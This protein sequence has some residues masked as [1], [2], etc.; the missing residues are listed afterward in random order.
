[1][2]GKLTINAN[3]RCIKKD[4]SFYTLIESEEL[5]TVIENLYFELDNE[6]RCQIMERIVQMIVQDEIDTE[7]MP[8]LVSCLSNT[9]SQQIKLDIFPA[10]NPNDEALIDSISTPLFVMFRNQFQLCKEEDNRRTLLARVL[11]ELQTIQPKIGYLLLY[12]LKIWGKEEE[13]REAEQRFV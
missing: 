8:T 13:K 2:A 10:N 11:A 4:L 9:L 1:L 3:A 7:T 5:R 12:F 6:T